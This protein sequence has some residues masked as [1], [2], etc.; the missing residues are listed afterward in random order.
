[1]NLYRERDIRSSIRDILDQTGAFDGVFLSG[2]PEDRGEPSGAARAVSIEPRETT[3]SDRWDDTSGSLVMTCRIALT[4]LA[5]HED[6]QIR[7]EAAELLVNTAANALNGQS[8]AGATL[9]GFTRIRGWSW[10]RPQAPERRIEAVLEFDY[11]LDNWAGFNT[12]E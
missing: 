11:L 2:L 4:F 8:L 3:Q 6:P 10:Q 5:R 7:D 9:P 1:V 12:S